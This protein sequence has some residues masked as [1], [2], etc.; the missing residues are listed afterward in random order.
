MRHFVHQ[1]RFA[2]C[3]EAVFALHER[4]GIFDLLIPPWQKVRLISREG[5]LKT[6]A[7]VE[8]RLLFGPFR[9]TWVAV[10]THY[11]HNRLFTDEQQQG[12]FAYWFHRHIFQPD[13]DGC[14]LRDDIEYSLPLGLDPILGRLVDKDLR[15]MFIYRHQATAR[16]LA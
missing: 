5:G 4:D 15:R 6:G 8:F 1:S 14:I 3:P 16:A 7:R 12:P 11:E 13:G 9:K 10:H 2:A